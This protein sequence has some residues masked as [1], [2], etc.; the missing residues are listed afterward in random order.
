[1]NATAPHLDLDLRLTAQLGDGILS[2]IGDLR[3]KGPVFW[4]EASQ[5]WFVSRHQDVIDGF[6]GRFPLSSRQFPEGLYRFFSP[7]DMARA[8]PN[9]I[10]YLSL[11]S[12]FLDPPAHTRV[13]SLLVRAFQR[14]I[15]EG[16]RPFV[17]QRVQE[18]LTYAAQRDT[19]EFNEEIARQLPGAVILRL[20]GLPDGLLSRLREWSNAFQKGFGAG[21]PKMEWLLEVEQA[22]TA[23]NEVFEAAIAE[24]RQNPGNDLISALLNASEKEDRL[25][26]DEVLGTLHLVII[27]GHD[28][29]ASSLTLGL[30][31][32][33][34]HPDQWMKLRNNPEL[35]SQAVLEI[36]RYSAMSSA[37]ARAATQDFEWHGK[38]IQRG[39]VVF[40]L[41]AGGN[42][43]PRAF[44][45]PEALDI[46]RDNAKSLTFAP[47]M[48]F[49][50]GHLLARMQLAEFFG[51]LVSR[52]D[53]A[54]LLDDPLD[55]MP[56]LVFRGVNS[57]N[58]RF[59]S[60]A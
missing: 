25:S 22:V 60:R 3:E 15:V 33:A 11:M 12:I 58:V 46:T 5:C 28:T 4:S 8:L 53:G 49:C 13:R 43:D 20:L 54:E 31:A 36:M 6:A 27:A 59:R 47:G 48:H 51:A 16:L 17:Q 21:I 50:V 18:L 23:M 24:R 35:A 1:M 14:N 32:L 55:F 19:V 42:R 30:A 39:Q 29:T 7:E 52:F 44:E 9:T 56:Q 57:L 40:L 34:R 10:R 26:H 38:T 45:N 41:I 37:Q 2:V